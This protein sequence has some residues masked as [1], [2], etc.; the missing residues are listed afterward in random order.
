MIE[1][2]NTKISI[3]GQCKLLGLSK[4][5]YYYQV[6]GE[7]ELN[8]HLMN[9]IDEQYMKTPFYG[10]E[11]MTAW[12]R[13]RGFAVNPK[14]VRRLMRMMGLEAIYPKPRLS[15]ALAEHKKNPYLLRDLKIEEPD[16]VWCADITYIRMVH[17]FMYLI[18]IMDWYS[19]YVL[20]W[21]LSNTLDTAFCLEALEKALAI[22]RPVI[23]NSDQGSQFT[24]FDFT[25]RLIAAKIRIS[26]DSRGRVFDNIFIERLWRSLKY[27]EVY[28][29]NYEN[30]YDARQSLEKYFQFYNEERLHESLD[31]AAPH[32]IYFGK[33][34]I[35]NRQA[36]LHLKEPSFLS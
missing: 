21:E 35:D 14:R 25:N 5:A 15:I 31:Y 24:S 20:S 10:V 16:Q 23:F 34:I 36:G 3:S 30:G 9:L 6:K 8:L 22:S 19:R 32:E 2:E 12:L 29:K 13:R 17:G 27:E 4:S 28:L 7:S 26:I 1:P 18:A 33:E 11:K